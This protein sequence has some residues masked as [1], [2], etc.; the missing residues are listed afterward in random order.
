MCNHLDLAGLEARSTIWH[1]LI[2]LVWSFLGGLNTKS[3]F[4]LQK[5]SHKNHSQEKIQRSIKNHCIYTRPL[6]FICAVLMIWLVCMTASFYCVWKC[7]C[8]SFNTITHPYAVADYIPRRSVLQSHVVM[9]RVICIRTSYFTASA[10]VCCS[11]I[12]EHRSEKNGTW[13]TGLSP[14]WSVLLYN[15]YRANLSRGLLFKNASR[16]T[17]IK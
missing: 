8:A 14:S 6:L 3:I 10:A 4:I 16:S 11:L 13:E 9:T 17:M 7:L 15:N 2:T 1:F 12:L 5:N